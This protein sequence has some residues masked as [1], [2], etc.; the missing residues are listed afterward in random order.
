MENFSKLNKR[1][2]VE[3]ERHGWKIFQ[4]LISGGTIIRY[5]RVH[6][7]INI[8]MPNVWTNIKT[9]NEFET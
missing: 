8:R 6:N 4:K 9:S 3:K 7:S 1:G 2:E 5:P